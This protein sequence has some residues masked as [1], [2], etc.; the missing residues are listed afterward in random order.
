MIRT[1][2]DAWRIGDAEI[3][4]GTHAYVRLP[5]ARMLTG[6]ETALPL[7]CVRGAAPGPTLSV[8]ACVHG[9][10][11]QPIRAL[12]NVLGRIDPRD[13]R[14]ALLLIPVANPFAFAHFSRQSPDQHE[15][16]NLWGAFPGLGSGTLTQRFAAAI[17]EALIDRADCLVE[18]HSGGMAGRIQRRVDADPDPES[19][20]GEE[21][22]RL[23]M[24]FASGGAG[25]VHG[26]PL[27]GSSA[28][29]CALARNIPA[30]SVE[31][32]GAYLPECEE[33]LYR[34]SLEGG[35]WN[36]LVHLGMVSGE[37][38]REKIV[39]FD[40]ADRAEANPSNGGY[41]LS[42]KTHF[43]D[44]G[45]AVRAG[46]LLGEMLDPFRLEVVEELRS[47]AD[48]VLFFSR[49]SGPL[50][51]GNKGFAVAAQCREMR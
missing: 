7:H 12:R 48:G 14:G 30:I 21:A 38:R 11:P 33:S 40:A 44:L 36:L 6:A 13:F 41:L 47:P 18:V 50:E 4:P 51:A 2:G 5:V 9:D 26:V 35:F 29:G 3:L 32:G 16:T 8:L 23:A 27:S 39:Y 34:D 28:S 24:A 49:C 45:G 17:R 20:A 25:M 46:E 15:Q 37:E 42:R 31:I 22:R 19:P 10:E 43:S 1:D